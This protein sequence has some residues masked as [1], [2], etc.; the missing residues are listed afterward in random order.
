MPT[1]LVTGGCGV[2]GSNFIRYWFERHPADE[3]VNVDLLT[4]AGD[5]ANVADVARDRAERYAFERADICDPAA[6]DAIVSPG[7]P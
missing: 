2:I 6:I 1:V 3:I 5:L 4:Y 7:Y